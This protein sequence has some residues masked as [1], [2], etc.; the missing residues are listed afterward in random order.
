MCVVACNMEKG[1]INCD[2]L[3][4]LSLER[5]SSEYVCIYVCI[6]VFVCVCVCVCVCMYI[7]RMGRSVCGPCSSSKDA[8]LH[9]IDEDCHLGIGL[10]DTPQP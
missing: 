10:T 4:Y 2:I 1:D 6:C 3:K 9:H 7:L 8:T 5:Q